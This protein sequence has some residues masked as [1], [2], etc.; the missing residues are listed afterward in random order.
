M[1]FENIAK[2]A[3]QSISGNIEK[4]I[5][6]IE[7]ERI[8]LKDINVE[9]AEA[10]K[11]TTAGLSR[12]SGKWSEA[13]KN[14]VNNVL[15]GVTK[16]TLPW[17]KGVNEMQE[18]AARSAPKK[19]RFEV[20][21][22]PSQITFQAVGGI[23]VEKRDYAPKDKDGK[24]SGDVQ[25]SY[26][27]MAPR[28]QMNL[29]LVFDDY[30]RTEA[31]MLEKFTDTTAIARTGINSAVTA[32]NGKTYSVRPQVEG[33]M[34][35]LRNSNTRKVTFYWGNMKYSGVM[36]YVNAEYTM[37][38][39]DGNPIRAN[40]NMSILLVDESLDYQ[41][42]GQWQISYQKVFGKEEA[43]NLGNSL[44]NAGNLLNINL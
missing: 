30:E 27:E 19:V 11:P 18:K 5:L 23:K 9:Q 39:T 31:F 25:I 21:F 28:I 35:A 41:C 20:K 24:A 7:D 16:T 15:E 37:F 34:G 8:R 12:I 14:T 36:T 10:R 29:Q 40:V 13:A 42:M 1:G 22:N 4:A 6:E 26:Q 3:G 44:Q 33:F 17:M 32:V 38:S 43:T 2:S